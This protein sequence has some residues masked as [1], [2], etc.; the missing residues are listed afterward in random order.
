MRIENRAYLDITERPANAGFEY[1]ISAAAPVI[2]NVILHVRDGGKI[3]S[4][5][6]VPEGASA[7]NRVK[8]DELYHRTDAETLQA[9][10]EVA[11]RAVLTIPIAKIF[12]LD[13]IGAAQ[14][15]V[16]SGVQGKVVLKH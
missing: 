7:E 4:I 3:V 1:A 6:P 10:A 2:G 11:S 8:I 15:A 16:S 12:R 13:E 14:R 9:V 5:V